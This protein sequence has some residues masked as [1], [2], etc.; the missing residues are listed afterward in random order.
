MTSTTPSIQFFGGIFEEERLGI[1]NWGLG[2]SDWELKTGKDKLVGI[3]KHW[4]L[5]TSDWGLESLNR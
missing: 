5:G 1:S 4:G 3:I 2:I